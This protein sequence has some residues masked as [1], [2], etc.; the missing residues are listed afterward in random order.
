[1]IEFK[2][3]EQKENS[4]ELVLGPEAL[5]LPSRW[6]GLTERPPMNRSEMTT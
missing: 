6:N 1:M 2:K 4:N 3:L 5:A